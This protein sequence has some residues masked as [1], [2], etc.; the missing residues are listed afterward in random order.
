MQRELRDRGHR[1]GRK[2]VA[3]LMR[4]H[5]L[6]GRAAGAGFGATTDSQHTLPV[7]PNVLARHFAVAAPN[8]AWVG[9]ITYLRTREGWLYL[10]VI[11]D[12]FSRR[13]VG[14][15]LGDAHHA[16]ARRSTRSAMALSTGGR[17]RGLLHHSD[18]GSQY[19]SADY[20]A[21]R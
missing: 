3:R 8:T 7:A 4:E 2:R 20:P 9:D 10:A 5:G 13:V 16:A 15:A 19:A 17:R 18:R 14:W 1:V 12:L 6:C 11:L 21:P